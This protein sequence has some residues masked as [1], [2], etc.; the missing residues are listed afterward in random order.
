MKTSSLPVFFDG[1]GHV[2][3]G[4]FMMS[5]KDSVGLFGYV[6]DGMIADIRIENSAICARYYVGGVVGKSSDADVSNCQNTGIIMGTKYVGGIIGSGKNVTDCQNGGTVL[7]DE[8]V[9]IVN[10]QHSSNIGGVAGYSITLMGCQNIGLVFGS[11]DVGGVAGECVTAQKC[12]NKGEVI[13]EF[14]GG[15]VCKGAVFN[16]LNEG[17]VHGGSGIV[18]EGS[19]VYCYNKGI[20]YGNSGVVGIGKA[21]D[22]ANEGTIYGNGGVV[23]SGTAVRCYNMG[24][25]VGYYMTGGVIGEGQAEYCYNVASVEGESFVGG[26]IGGG[27]AQFCYNTGNVSGRDYVGGIVGLKHVSDFARYCYNIGNVSGNESVGGVVGWNNNES[28]S[29]VMNCYYLSGCAVYHNGTVSQGVGGGNEV[30]GIIELTAD[31]MMQEDSYNSFFNHV[32]EWEMGG[33]DG[34]AYPTLK[35]LHHGVHV[36]ENK[37]TTANK[38]MYAP[39]DC[40][41]GAQ[42]FYSCTKCEAMGFETFIYGDAQ[43]PMGEEW[44]SD[45]LEHW[46]VCTGCNAHFEQETHIWEQGTTVKLPT[47]KEA[48][49]L[50]YQCT[51]C[52][53]SI[54]MTLSAFAS[55]DVVLPTVHTRKTYHPIIFIVIGAVSGALVFYAVV[56]VK[57]VLPKKK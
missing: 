26:I 48:G 31:Q 51:V 20:V 29:N 10:N 14:A 7:G 43:H 18:R 49:E 37:R 42:Y 47:A 22:C 25:I 36:F 15:I 12:R 56:T 46:R 54:K 39:A 23:D 55:S 8:F 41:M 17:M 30:S 33:S 13:G 19:A 44:E 9:K 3:S 28:S 40:K 16:C 27:S 52:G 5:E 21:T 1:G 2:I 53:Q 38:Y 4:L 34:Y 24:N 50:A 35:A 45:T 57:K 11:D 32:D 6:Q